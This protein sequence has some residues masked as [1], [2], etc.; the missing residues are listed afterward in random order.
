M[1]FRS[2]FKMFA[3]AASLS[4]FVACGGDDGD[5]GPTDPPMSILPDCPAGSDTTAGQAVFDNNCSSCHPAFAQASARAGAPV[6]TAACGDAQNIAE[7]MFVRADMTLTMPPD[8]APKL[9]D[10]QA[11]D[12]TLWLACTQ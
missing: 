6:N 11:N 8:P 10:Q 5:D 3:L 4:L 2:V 7:C 12:L 9:T 1:Q